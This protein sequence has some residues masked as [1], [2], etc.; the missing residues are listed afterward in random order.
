MAVPTKLLQIKSDAPVATAGRLPVLENGEGISDVKGTAGAFKSGGPLLQSIVTSI[1][2]GNGTLLDPLNVVGGYVSFEDNVNPAAWTLPTAASL[3]SY[4]DRSNFG[5]K[6]LVGGSAS[7]DEI[8]LLSAFDC[9]FQTGTGADVTL[10]TNTG[11]LWHPNGIGTLAV[12]APT[13]IVLS[14][15]TSTTF[16]FFSGGNELMMVR[17][18]GEGGGGG[19][20]VTSVGLTMPAEFAVANSPVV[21]AGSLAVTKTTQAR[22][23]VYAGPPLVGDAPAPPTF[24]ALV[25]LDLPF[26]NWEGCI[27]QAPVFNLVTPAEQIVGPMTAVYDAYPLPGGG[28]GDHFNL[29]TG[30]LTLP[31]ANGLYLIWGHFTIS[32]SAIT[33][34]P[35][36]CDFWLTK[37]GLGN[38]AP[39]FMVLTADGT[40]YTAHM[41]AYI[42]AG[43]TT[44][45]YRLVVRSL[46]EYT[47]SITGQWGCYPM[48][49]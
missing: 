13:A 1:A 32:A 35:A 6:Q 22:N 41:H 20:T 28:F 27:L 23:L 18:S 36:R 24:R 43:P 38:I 4:I 48:L 45:V 46:G 12:P 9:V 26:V 19:G 5:A 30:M 15:E 8:D 39:T 21:G 33:V 2:Q 40:A 34:T 25:P 29:L 37:N 11:I 31:R 10:N 47:G 49:G 17:L 7:Y 3:F 44:D 42:Y 16:R 14:A